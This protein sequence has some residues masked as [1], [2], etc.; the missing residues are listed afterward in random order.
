MALDDYDSMA[1]VM[2]V[3]TSSS[4]FP[5]Q[6]LEYKSVGELLYRLATVFWIFPKFLKANK[7]LHFFSFLHLC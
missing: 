4:T 7:L 2:A 5:E 1:G 3:R 6:I